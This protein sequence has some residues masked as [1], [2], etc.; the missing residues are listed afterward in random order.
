[1]TMKLGVNFESEG[2]G[3]SDLQNNME[4]MIYCCAVSLYPT[5]TTLYNIIDLCI[6]ALQIQ[7]KA[8]G[9]F[10]QTPSKS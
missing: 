10:S 2:S 1:M 9:Y 3:I 8:Q 6:L 4:A 5:F 7:H